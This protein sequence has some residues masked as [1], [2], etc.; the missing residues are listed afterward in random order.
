MEIGNGRSIAIS[1]S[2]LTMAVGESNFRFLALKVSLALQISS[3]KH[4]LDV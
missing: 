4:F 2:M 1:V 3:E